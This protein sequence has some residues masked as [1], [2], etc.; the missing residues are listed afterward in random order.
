MKNTGTRFL[1]PIIDWKSKDIWDV[2]NGESIPVCEMYSWGYERIGCIACPLAKKCQREREIYDFPKYKAAYISAFNKM[3][4][5]RKARG[6]ETKWSCGEEVY[7]W[8]MQSN[9]VIGQ[10][11]LDDF[12]K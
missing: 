2:I 10:M 11:T 9:D 3:L 12:I 4:D 6:K 5:E 8:W 7:L 1:N